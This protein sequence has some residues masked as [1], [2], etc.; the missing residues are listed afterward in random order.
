MAAG[1]SRVDQG[2]TTHHNITDCDPPTKAPTDLT[3]FGSFG[4]CSALATSVA[5]SDQPGSIFAT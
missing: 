4:K 1:L 5:E 3:R 2:A